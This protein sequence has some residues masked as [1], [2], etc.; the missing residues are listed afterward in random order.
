MHAS[1]P[2]QHKGALAVV[3]LS[4]EGPEPELHVVLGHLDKLISLSPIVEE[5]A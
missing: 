4:Q 5:V 1:P 3:V 2:P